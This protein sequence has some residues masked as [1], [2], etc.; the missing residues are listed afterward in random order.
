MTTLLPLLKNDVGLRPENLG[1]V[2]LGFAAATLGFAGK[3]NQLGV[4]FTG[5]FAAAVLRGAP[6]LLAM[7]KI[8]D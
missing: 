5:L 7:P 1:A 3:P 8:P 4:T 6:K 2:F